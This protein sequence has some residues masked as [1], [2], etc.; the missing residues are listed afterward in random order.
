MIQNIIKQVREYFYSSVDFIAT[1]AFI[2]SGCPKG[3]LIVRL[4]VIGD[5]IIWLDSAKELRR[6]FPDRK[7]TLLANES[8]SDLALHFDYWDEV[9]PV[10]LKG[11]IN[12]PFYRWKILRM[13]RQKGF[14][15]ALSAQFSR[16]FLAGDSIVRATGARERIG[17]VGD[18]A[19]MTLQQKRVSD[20]WYTR[21]LPAVDKPL[22]EV[23]R[24]AEIISALAGRPYTPRISAFS[25]LL[26]LPAELRP[27]RPYF[28][29]F[30]G[31]STLIKQW[32]LD[33]FAAV[34]DQVSQR[35]DLL[36]VLCGSPSERA[37]C[38]ELGSRAGSS[39]ID[40]SGRTS[41]AELAEVIR[42]ARFLVGN[43]T[44]AVHIAAA[45]G[46]PSVCILGGGHYGRFMPYPEHLDGVKPLAAMH[47]MECFNCNWA[48]VQTD[49][50][51]EP[52]PCVASVS[53]EQVMERVREIILSR[54]RAEK[55]EGFCS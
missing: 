21:L 17:S 32:P 25:P 52:Y 27:A 2:C 30:P 8:W 44:S 43:D 20:Q 28:I 50:R 19:N 12:K 55:F 9:I 26:E 53:V 37:L 3:V 15:I 40:Y 46:A 47:R 14:A 49:N 34:I 42:G 41:L 51:D 54:E 33:Q 6:C 7:I 24:N 16:V 4:D 36:P 31:A 23:D 39:C 5:F 11:L 10:S 1:Q 18:L 38:A 45:V 48:C 35:Y 29:I 22:M 13:V